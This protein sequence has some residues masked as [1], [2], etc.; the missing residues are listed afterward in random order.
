MDKGISNELAEYAERRN[1]SMKRGEKK[2]TSKGLKSQY[3]KLVGLVK[4]WGYSLVK[5][6]LFSYFV[7]R[8][9]KQFSI[10]RNHISRNGGLR[11]QGYGA[12]RPY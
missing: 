4:K 7:F 5:V 9:E 1:K 3:A 11:K 10:M 6:A 12:F 2:S 8:V